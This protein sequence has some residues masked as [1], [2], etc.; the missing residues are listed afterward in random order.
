MDSVPPED[1]KWT[2]GFS[3]GDVYS[4][5]RVYKLVIGVLR[6]HSLI[7]FFGPKR[8]PSTEK[9]HQ[10]LATE[11]LLRLLQQL[12]EIAQNLQVDVVETSV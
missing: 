7:Y 8:S 2:T 1:N 9:P 12:V 4:F 11:V 5:H 6:L 3:D 10:D